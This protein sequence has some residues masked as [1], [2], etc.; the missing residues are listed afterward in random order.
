MRRC[1]YSQAKPSATMTGNLWLKADK[2]SKAIRED[3]T[4][5]NSKV[6]GDFHSNSKVMECNKCK[7]P[8]DPGRKVEGMARYKVICVI[9]FMRSLRTCT[10]NGWMRRCKYSQAKPTA[11]MTGNLWLK[12]GKNSKAIQE[13][14]TTNNS[15]VMGDSHN[16]SKVM[17]CNK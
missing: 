3:L 14:L 4:T 6:M 7:C 1:K 9:C 12:A 2:N 15:K 13:D 10:G 8:K 17:E 16:N 5:N 11:T